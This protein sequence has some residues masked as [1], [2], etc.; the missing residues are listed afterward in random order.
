MLVVVAGLTV[1][2]W[3]TA[4]TVETRVRHGAVEA[5]HARA[6]RIQPHTDAAGA[7]QTSSARGSVSAEPVH[8]TTRFTFLGPSN[9]PEVV[10]TDPSTICAQ[11]PGTLLAKGC[12]RVG[13]W[14]VHSVDA[15]RGVESI[16]LESLIGGRERYDLRSVNPS[17]GALIDRAT[18]AAFHQLGST[19]TV[20][21]GAAE[22]RG[23]L[24]AKNVDRMVDHG[25][26]VRR[27]RV[28]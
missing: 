11:A 2:S 27:A 22:D 23:T 1:V 3:W 13:V 6:G 5:S 12:D 19:P 14:V 28:G 18:L 4:P 7:A 26:G 16:A 21:R 20:A 25:P 8:R 24:R 10:S 9:T 15:R 17:A